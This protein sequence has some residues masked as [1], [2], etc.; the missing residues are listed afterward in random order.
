L[1]KA[2]MT[3]KTQLKQKKKK[4]LFGGEKNPATKRTT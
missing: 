1:K 4:G 2:I 3:E